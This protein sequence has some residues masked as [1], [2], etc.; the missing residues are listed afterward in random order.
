MDCPEIGRVVGSTDQVE[1]LVQVH[2][3][4]EV[5]QPPSPRDYAFGRFVQISVDPASRLIGVIYTTQLLNPAY[6]TLGPRLSTEQELPVFS[7]DYLLETAIVVGVTVLGSAQAI[8]PDQIYDQHTP[9]LAATVDAPCVLLP[10][11]DELAFH[12]AGGRVR[13]GYFPRLL[14]RPFPALPDLLCSILDRLI[15]A[16]P[17][18]KSQLMVARQNILWRATIQGR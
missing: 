9:R 8:G 1:Y 10:E 15:V 6:G 4:G 12:R 3:A 16:F 5:Q 14:A 13:L 2:G 18:E 11:P 7:P 17:E